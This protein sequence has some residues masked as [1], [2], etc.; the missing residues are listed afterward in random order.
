MTAVDK[1]NSVEAPRIL[2]KLT[3]LFIVI[4]LFPA[5]VVMRLFSDGPGLL[6]RRHCRFS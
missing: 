5:V 1:S 4:I 3:G 2:K 6:E